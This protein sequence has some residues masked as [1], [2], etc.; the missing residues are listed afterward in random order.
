MPYIPS[1]RKADL[2][3]ETPKTVGELTFVLQ[4]EIQRYLM[5]RPEIRYADLAAVLGALEGAKADF[6]E[7]IL[8]PY[9]EKAL[10]RNGDVW[11]L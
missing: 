4:R 7:R 1:E 10:E 8:I 2:V 11:S 5:G 6:I 9:E 3:N